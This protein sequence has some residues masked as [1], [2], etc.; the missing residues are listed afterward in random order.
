MLLSSAS[1]YSKFDKGENKDLIETLGYSMDAN[2]LH[3][4]QNP[5]YKAGTLIQHYSIH[6]SLV[7]VSLIYSIIITKTAL[8]L[9]YD[10]VTNF[11]PSVIYEMFTSAV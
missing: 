4:C 2:N 6:F 5:T 10:F 1:I 3:E 9:G 11:Q 8:Y 7:V